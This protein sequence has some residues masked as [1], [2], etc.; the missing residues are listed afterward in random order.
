MNLKSSS[1]IHPLETT[2]PLVD[3]CNY[4]S[5][6]LYKNEEILSFGGYQTH[7]KFVSTKGVTAVSK[8][9]YVNLLK[10]LYLIQYTQIKAKK[11]SHLPLPKTTELSSLVSH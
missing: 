5:R 9:H 8:S 4:T 1:Y 2:F 10:I 7:P 11:V 6:K 3:D